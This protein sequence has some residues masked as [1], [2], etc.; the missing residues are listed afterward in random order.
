M[1]LEHKHVK[2]LCNGYIINSGRPQ[3]SLS[4]ILLFSYWISLSTSVM[5]E[6]DLTVDNLSILIDQGTWSDVEMNV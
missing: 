4:N 6:I 3:Q 5:C 2:A 1:Y